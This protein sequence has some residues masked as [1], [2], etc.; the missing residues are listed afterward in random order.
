MCVCETETN[1]RSA[2]SERVCASAYVSVSSSVSVTICIYIR[3]CMFMWNS[4]RLFFFHIRNTKWALHHAHTTPNTPWMLSKEPCILWKELF[5]LKRSRHAKERERKRKSG[6][7]EMSRRRIES[8]HV[9][10]LRQK[11]YMYI[12]IYIYVYICIYIY[13]YICIYTSICV[14]IIY[15]YIYM[16]TSN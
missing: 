16:Y 14:N 13:L 5:I 11:I 15:I 2:T 4:T 3:L 6:I 9:L 8:C 7:E 10:E 1:S 12:H